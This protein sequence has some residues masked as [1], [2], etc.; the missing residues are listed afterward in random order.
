[1]LITKTFVANVKAKTTPTPVTGAINTPV[2]NL[3]AKPLLCHGKVIY[4]DNILSH[5]DIFG[6]SVKTVGEL[7]LG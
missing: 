3:A 2:H 5:I 4:S 7:R 1:M 6:S